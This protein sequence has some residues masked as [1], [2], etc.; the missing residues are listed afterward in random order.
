[1]WEVSIKEGDVQFL[2]PVFRREGIEH[3][4]GKWNNCSPDLWLL[5]DR[6]ASQLHVWDT[7]PENKRG[8]TMDAREAP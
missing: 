1:M 2:M 4:H 6:S 5:R 8:P 7:D 3:D